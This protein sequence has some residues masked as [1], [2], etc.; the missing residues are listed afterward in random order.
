MLS[1]SSSQPLGWPTVPSTQHV[2]VQAV[3]GVGAVQPSA[4]DT[5]AGT[6]RQGQQSPRESAP[7][8]TRQG[9]DTSALGAPTA[10][11]APLLPRDSTEAG[12]SDTSAETA[13]ARAEQQEEERKAR[14]KAEQR[15]PL[16][17]VL[18][19]VWKASAAVVE[20]VLGRDVDVATATPGAASTESV[21]AELPGIESVPAALR[22]EQEPVA[23]TEQGT[24]SWAPLE[25]GSLISRR[26]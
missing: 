15:Q 7:A 21:Q 1:I 22:R 13:Q 2:A 14:E 12:E 19:T 8:A 20:V 26:V 4:R 9:A 5:Q 3:P 23:Y 18:S 11:P 17:E 6:G 24:S 25:A 16:Q 10:Q